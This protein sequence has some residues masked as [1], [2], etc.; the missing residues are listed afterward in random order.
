M[1]NHGTFHDNHL[2]TVYPEHK[3]YGDLHHHVGSHRE[4]S[5]IL[6]GPQCVQTG[7]C[8]YDWPIRSMTSSVKTAGRRTAIS[9][10]IASQVTNNHA[11]SHFSCHVDQTERRRR[12]MA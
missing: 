9:A 1:P 2:H 11:T 7:V 8:K 12:R 6:G 3:T 10:M 4:I 5:V